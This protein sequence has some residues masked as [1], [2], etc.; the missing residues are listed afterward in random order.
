MSDR[1]YIGNK[2]PNDV[3]GIVIHLDDTEDIK[4][5][6]DGSISLISGAHHNYPQTIERM[7]S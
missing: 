4:V 5:G 2:L 1:V 3:E 7:L 6:D